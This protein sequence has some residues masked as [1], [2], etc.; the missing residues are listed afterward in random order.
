LLEDWSVIPK[1]FRSDLASIPRCL[2]WLIAPFELSI[3]APLLHDYLYK[4]G[5]LRRRVVD[6]VFL[7]LME[8]EGVPRWRRNAA[9]LAVRLFGA[10]AY[11]G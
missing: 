5:R 1:G 7:G 9:Y 10:P 2:W 8:S 11:Q 3:Q 6:R 4:R